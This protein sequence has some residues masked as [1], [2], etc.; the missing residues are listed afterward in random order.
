MAAMLGHSIENSYKKVIEADAERPSDI[1]SLDG[2]V[3][4]LRR[5]IDEYS[6]RSWSELSDEDL[7]LLNKAYRILCARIGVQSSRLPFR[8]WTEYQRWRRREQWDQSR[9]LQST[10]TEEIYW[11][12]FF[13]ALEEHLSDVLEASWTQEILRAVSPHDRTGWE[14]VDTEIEELRRKFSIA[15]TAADHSGVGH[16]SVRVIE[17]LAVVA[18]DPRIHGAFA[19][20]LPKPTDTKNRLEAIIRA[21]ASGSENEVLRKLSKDIV[22]LAQEVKHRH[23][24][25]RADAGVAADSVIF[26]ANVMRRLTS[27]PITS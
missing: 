8:D 21:H 16:Q 6:R 25:D 15:R 4:L 1:D 13:G 10:H 12:D 5:E 27:R 9:Q 17:K 19:E 3:R 24:P 22:A 26:L 23:T 14:S 20:G 11:D 18:Y 7:D 2:V